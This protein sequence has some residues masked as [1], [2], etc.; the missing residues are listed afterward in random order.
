MTQPTPAI[1]PQSAVRRLPRIAL[2]LFCA[3]YVLP[4]LFGRE[5]WKG[6]EFTA[7]GHMLALAQ[8]A[9][10]WFNPQIWGQTPELDD[11]SKRA[12]EWTT[13]KVLNLTA[14]HV[15]FVLTVFLCVFDMGTQITLTQP[16][17]G[18]G[19]ISQ[20]LQPIF[21]QQIHRTCANQRGQNARKNDLI[22]CVVARRQKLIRRRSDH[23]EPFPGF[24]SGCCSQ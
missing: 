6:N 9:S 23:S 12:I 4:G 16:V 5:P 3:A 13:A 24:R 21:K 15:H 17:Q 20:C 7:F 10:D 18:I 22:A 8:G 1:V 14:D 2:W 11:R 19:H